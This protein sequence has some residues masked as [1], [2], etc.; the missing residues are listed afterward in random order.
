M[1][2]RLHPI[3]FMSSV[4]ILV[5]STAISGKEGKNS[6]PPLRSLQD[7]YSSYREEVLRVHPFVTDNVR[8]MVS[9]YG[10]Q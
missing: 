7:H 6:V 8:I 4:L 1:T 3:R 5:F 2:V 9:D 10:R